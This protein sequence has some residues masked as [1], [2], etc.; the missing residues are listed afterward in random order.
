M[1]AALALSALTLAV[2]V[3]LLLGRGFFWQ[4]E[5]EPVP[6]HPRRWPRVTAIVPA[7]DESQTVGRAVASLLAQDYPGEF[8]VVLVDD[9][10]QDGT[11]EIARDAASAS[12]RSENLRVV[13]ARALPP[14]WSGKLWA[15]SE[16][17][18]AAVEAAKTARALSLHRRRYRASPAEPVRA[19]GAAGRRAGS[20]SPRSWSNSIAAAR[21]RNS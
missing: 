4:A 17:V 20:I 7:R 5:E 15:L 21:P 9:H 13:S 19:G 1:S 6:E 10:S 14:G 3:Y 11:A 2:W 16:G 8:S 18:A 12:G